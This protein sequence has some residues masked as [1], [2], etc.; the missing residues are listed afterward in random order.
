MEENMQHFQHI[1]LYYFKKGKNVT[2]MQKKICAAYREG[3]VMD[4]MCQKWFEKFHVGDFSL[5]DAPQSGRP[6]EAGGNQIKALIE[7]N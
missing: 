5:D 3:A 6:A 4:W 2:E 7:N 1:M